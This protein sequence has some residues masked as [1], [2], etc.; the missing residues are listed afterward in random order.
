MWIS[1]NCSSRSFFFVSD[2][3]TITRPYSIG[4]ALVIDIF[5]K[6]KCIVP[7]PSPK[8]C[9]CCQSLAFRFPINHKEMP[10]VPMDLFLGQNFLSSTFRTQVWRHRRWFLSERPLFFTSCKWINLYTKSLLSYFSKIF[11][12]YSLWVVAGC[13]IQASN[14]MRSSLMTLLRHSRRDPPW[15]I[16]AIKALGF[17]CSLETDFFKSL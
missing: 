3:A 4:T 16:F 17:F 7:A 12:A 6:T 1:F 8:R 2:S 15:K 13:F 5:L 14:L 10:G 11:L 9:L